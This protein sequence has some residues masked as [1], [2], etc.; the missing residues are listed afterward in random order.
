LSS[1]SESSS[2]AATTFFFCSQVCQV[3]ANSDSAVFLRHYLCICL[4]CYVNIQCVRVKET[5]QPVN[6]CLSVVHSTTLQA[7]ELGIKHYNPEGW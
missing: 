3:V 5:I 6:L 4:L 7:M 1:E 2:V